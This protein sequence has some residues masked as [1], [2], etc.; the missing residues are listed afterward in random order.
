MFTNIADPL[1]WNFCHNTLPE[2]FKDA[3]Q[4]RINNPVGLQRKYLALENNSKWVNLRTEEVKA[5]EQEAREILVKLF[6]W[7]DGLE[8]TNV[9][10]RHGK[11]RNIVAKI[12]NR[13]TRW[14]KKCR[15]IG[16]GTG[17]QADL[18]RRGS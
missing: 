17:G 6:D 11:S 2:K 1:S 4:F 15:G 14:V 12:F 9:G 7:L 13:L 3:R 8:P 5:A 18:Y 10:P 16:R